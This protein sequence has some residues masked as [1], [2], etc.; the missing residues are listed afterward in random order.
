[1]I[2]IKPH[3]LKRAFYYPETNTKSC[4]KCGEIKD[5]LLFFK[6]NQTS[7]GYHSWCKPCCKEGNDRSREKKYATFEGRI[8]TFLTSCKKNAE[9]RKNEFSLTREDLM[10]MWEQQGGLCCY[11]G[12]QMTT[13]AAM[14]NSVSVERVDNSI[15]YT[16]DNTVLVCNGVNSMKSAMNGEDFFHFCKA[17]VDWLGDENGELKVDFRKYD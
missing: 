4:A 8:S 10:E 11:T 15:G 3:P 5:L 1:M 7:D 12:I 13:Q 17:V 14:P 16:R 9:K 6:H 2:T